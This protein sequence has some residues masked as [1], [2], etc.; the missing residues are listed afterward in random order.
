ME[1]STKLT[2]EHV[3]NLEQR[4]WP[5]VEPAC[6]VSIGLELTKEMSAWLRVSISL[7]EKTWTM[8]GSSASCITDLSMAL[9]F[10][11]SIQHESTM[12]R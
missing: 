4:L 3:G 7:V 5:A 11:E 2:L 6:Y 10:L 8:A 12:L 1:Y 9:V